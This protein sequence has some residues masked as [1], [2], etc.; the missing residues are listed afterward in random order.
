M[1]LQRGGQY[2]AR[3]G[4]PVSQVGRQVRHRAAEVVARAGGGC[5]V[6]GVDAL[7]VLEPP[8]HALVAGQPLFMAREKVPIQRGERA[9][10]VARALCRVVAARWMCM[11]VAAQGLLAIAPLLANWL[12]PSVLGNSAHFTACTYTLK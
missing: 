12:M 2:L 9:G 1:V 10:R 5:W 7:Q 8:R 3:G 11:P 6:G 4:E